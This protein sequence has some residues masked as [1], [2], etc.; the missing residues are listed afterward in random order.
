MAKFE[1][2]IAEQSVILKVFIQDS[3]LSTGAGLA[4]L[5]QTS[6]IVGGYVKRDGT[7]VAL[8]VDENVTTEGTYQAPSAVGKV[9]IGTPA[10]MPVGW[11][12]LHFHND[13]FTATDWVS[14]GLYVV[15]GGIVPVN[16][17]VQ[18]KDSGN[19]SIFRR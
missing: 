6:S 13:L 16:I 1:L 5:D 19:N 10:N 11:Y 14:I 4:A 18:L 17:E 3:T 8:A 2:K 12:E 9:R 15:A 7:G